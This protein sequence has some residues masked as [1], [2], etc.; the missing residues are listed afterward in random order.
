MLIGGPGR[1]AS[2]QPVRFRPG[3]ACGWPTRPADGNLGQPIGKNL[4][5]IK[6]DFDMP[7]RKGKMPKK[8][9]KE[10]INPDNYNFLHKYPTRPA[11]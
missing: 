9:V 5:L 4:Q 11:D 7:V 3:P 6:K 1:S 2:R 8:S 10:M